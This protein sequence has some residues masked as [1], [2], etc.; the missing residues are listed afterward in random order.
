MYVF[1]CV[2]EVAQDPPALGAEPPEP[3]RQVGSGDGAA[4]A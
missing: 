4:D 1:V 2:N 3:F